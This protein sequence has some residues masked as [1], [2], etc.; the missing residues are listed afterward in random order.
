M[1]RDVDEMK[2]Q[3]GYSKAEMNRQIAAIRADSDRSE[4]EKEQEIQSIREFHERLKDT[5]REKMKVGQR[6]VREYRAST[7]P[8]RSFILRE[9]GSQFSREITPAEPQPMESR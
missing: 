2:R 5:Y 7:E 9:K 1:E 6:R 4:A 8:I 3:L